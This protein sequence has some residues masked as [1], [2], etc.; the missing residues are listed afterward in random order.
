MPSETAPSQLPGY[1]VRRPLAVTVHVVG[2]NSFFLFASDRFAIHCVR[3]PLVRFISGDDIRGH[4]GCQNRLLSRR[5]SR[6]RCSRAPAGVVLCCATRPCFE[7]N[8]FDIHE[9]LGCVAVGN[10]TTVL[11][12]ENAKNEKQKQKKFEREMAC[13][14][15]W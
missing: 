5:V 7:T 14:R 4:F 12:S 15:F 13:K 9:D 6:E 2:S 11:R 8:K 1:G 10:D 3:P